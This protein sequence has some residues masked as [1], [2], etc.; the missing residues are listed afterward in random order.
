LRG[1]LAK[2]VVAAALNVSLALSVGAAP[3]P[4]ARK[5]LQIYFVDVEGGQS[6]LFV[7][8]EGK[9][10]L[11]DTGWPDNSGRDADR[12][13]AAAKD[14]GIKKIDFVLITH[15]HDDH[16]GGAP[17]LAAKIPV[18]TFIDHGENRETGNAGN[19]K[20][21]AAYQQLLSGGKYKHIMAKPGEV[22]PI[23][24]MQVRV[25]TANGE[26]IERPLPG[27]GKENTNCANAPKPPVDVTENPRSVGT[28]TT[29][30]KLRIL[31]LGDLTG[32][33]ELELMC[34]M[35]KIGTVDIYVASHHGT[36][37]SGTP[38]LVHAITPRVVIMDNGEKKGGS[39]VAW[40]VIQ[41]SP[42]LENLWQLHYSAEG[43]DAHNVEAP[44]VA[45]LQ[46]PDTGKYLKITASA[47]GSFAVL[48]SRTGETK[49]YAPR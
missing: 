13:A 25:V 27:G 1:Q 47:D 35:N 42:G 24:G 39:Q 22:L 45:N 23:T 33:K 44:R 36:A 10:L 38:V 41:K 2:A 29:F 5:A 46:G 34:P 40:D 31:D 19:A 21:F 6:T 28:L 16:V 14:A 17:Q 11:I 49:K 26:L 15:Y 30:G 32:D 4:E 20:V 9:S 12:I 7:T 3:A 48:N 8:P 43:G 37:S 18:G